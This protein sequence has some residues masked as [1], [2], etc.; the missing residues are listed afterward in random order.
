M[1]REFMLDTDIVRRAL[2]GQG[3]VPA[4]VLEHRPSQLCVSS[5]TLAELRY[6]ADAGGSRK[7]HGLIDT[8]FR[9]VAV[10]PFDEAAADR[11][12]R[13]ASALARR[14]E[15]LGTFDTLIAAHALSCGLTLVTNNTKHFQRVVGLRMANWL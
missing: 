14:G 3:E 2:R 7:L 15:P 9:S 8:I 6:G 13:V 4:R 12:G 11:F 1:M 10:L 5:I